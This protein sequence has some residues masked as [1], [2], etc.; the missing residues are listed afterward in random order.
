MRE[1]RISGFH[2]KQLREHLFPGD[3]KEA[4]A[5]ALCGRHKWKGKQTLLVHKLVIIPYEDCKIREP[6]LVKWSTNVLIPHLVDASKKGWAVVK[7]HSH[8]NGYPD[9]SETDN[10]SDKELFDSV[11]GWMNDE[12]P[13]GSMIMLPDGSLFGRFIESNLEF[14][15]IDKISLCGDD[16]K[17]WHNSS[18]DYE[19]AGFN[20]RTKQTFGEGTIQL[21]KRLKVGVIGC[22]GTGSPTVEQLVRL[23]VG[24]LVLIDPDKVEEKNLNRIL[25]TTMSDAI[26]S[27]YKVDVLNDIIDKIGLGTEVISF[28]NNLYDSVDVIHELASC[29]IIFGCVDSVDGRH[30]INQIAN[31]YLVPY[32]DL[33]VKVIADGK[34]SVDQICG[35][36]NYLQ[37]RGSSLMS[38]GLYSNEELRAA[39]LH[40]VNP[41]EYEVQKKSGYIVNVNVDSPAVISINMQTASIAVN[42]FL[43][44]IHPFR[45]DPNSEFA[46][47]RFSITDAYVQRESDGS[48][49]EYLVKYVGRGDI[50]PL[51]NMP[52]LS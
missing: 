31:F 18:P 14:T 46:I 45:Y 47:T 7:V 35:T 44:R 13:H 40:R 42:E 12:N 29:D 43:A 3:G 28:K 48:P 22:S 23:G 19:S 17:Y 50:T 37:P 25:N 16:I 26:K 15:P 34:G 33:G 32:F 21:L 41:E 38:R 10:F 51:L 4:V 2:Y 30:L 24:S 8:P 39:G 9:F 49:D 27:R 5:V 1:L 36:I 52:E 6:D 20:I 11:F